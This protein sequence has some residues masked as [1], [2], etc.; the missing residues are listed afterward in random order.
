MQF[1]ILISVFKRSRYAYAPVLI[2]GYIYIEYKHAHTRTTTP[3]SVMFTSVC[4]I[5]LHN[6][7]NAFA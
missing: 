2:M 1:L 6:N 3:Y 5:K 7:S 4:T